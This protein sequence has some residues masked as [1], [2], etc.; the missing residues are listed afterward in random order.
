MALDFLLGLFVYVDF[1]SVYFRDVCNDSS[2]EE[3]EDS[4]KKEKQEDKVP[5]SNI[6]FQVKVRTKSY[7]QISFCFIQIREFLSTKHLPFEELDPHDIR[8]GFSLREVPNIVS[9]F[10]FLLMFTMLFYFSSGNMRIVSV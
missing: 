7:K 4:D 8:V 3:T 10:S 9:I 6:I 5:S 1:A 2:Q